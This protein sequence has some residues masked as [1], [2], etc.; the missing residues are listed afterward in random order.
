MARSAF[1]D[2]ILTALRSF[3]AAILPIFPNII[4]PTTTEKPNRTL[5]FQGDS[6]TDCSRV[7]DAENSHCAEALGRGYVSQLAGRIP[8]HCPDFNWRIFNKGISG[9]R[10][11]SLYARWQM[12][13]LQIKPDILSILVGVNDVWHGLPEREVFNGVPAGHFDRSYRA[14]LTFTREQLPDVQLILGEPFLLQGTAYSEVF[15]SQLAERSEIVRAIASD[16][17]ATW[18]PYQ[19]AFDQ[20]LGRFSVAELA[21]DGV[22]PSLIGHSLM[23]E[24]WL[25]A[26]KGRCGCCK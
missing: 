25:N 22:H 21:P 4:M 11:T 10:I 7:R 15:A 1:D 17:N 14:L 9:D 13:A 6:I 2:G 26:F 19:K 16:F 23:A 8:L 18:V 5:L 12:D 24:N 20:A 3:V